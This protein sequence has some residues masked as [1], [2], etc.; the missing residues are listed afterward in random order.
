MSASR[1]TSVHLPPR[2]WGAATAAGDTWADLVEPA[3]APVPDAVSII[4]M[5]SDEGVR[6]NRGRVGAALGPDAIRKTL[7]R[8]SFHH[9]VAMAD[10]GDVEVLGADLEAGQERLGQVVAPAVAN[11]LTVVLGGGHET[12]YGTYL[13]L[14]RAGYPRPGRRL[15]I[16]NIDAHFDLRPDRP[17]TSGT[18]FSQMAEELGD[19]FHYAVVGI[20]RPNNSRI[21]FAEAERLS[22]DFLDDEEADD[23]SIPPFL[24]GL[25]DAADDV[26]LTIDLDA[27]PASTCP[28]VSA[29]AAFGLRL[30][31][32][33]AAVRQ[34]AGSGKLRVADV[35]EINPTLDIDRRTARVAARVVDTIVAGSRP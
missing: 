18:P 34:V 27:L 21:L 19:D 13:G 30:P 9:D 14:R 24:Q 11:G 33:L 31:Y 3:A 5:A 10:L 25:L 29:P 2:P 16:I 12:A 15:Q 35:V 6:R 7:G 1:P 26:Y 32:V 28:G 8:W 22:V 17:G 20:S 23:V 4:G